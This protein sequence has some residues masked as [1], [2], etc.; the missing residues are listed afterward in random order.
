MALPACIDAGLAGIFGQAAAFLA[1]AFVVALVAAS[2]LGT[3]LVMW[4]YRR[5]VMTY[6][7]LPAPEPSGTTP[8][9]RPRP[10]PGGSVTASALVAAA[11]ARRAHLKRVLLAAC[12]L[13]ALAVAS[14]LTL[15]PESPVFAP[16]RLPTVPTGPRL[17][18]TALADLGLVGAL[19][20]PMVLIGL[21]HPRLG[22]LFWTRAVPLFWGALTLRIAAAS[23]DPVG[24]FIVL[25]MLLVFVAGPQVLVFYASIARRRARQLVPML[26][27]LLGL[28]FAGLL[29]AVA[30]M[31]LLARCGDDG[32]A[33]LLLLSLPLLLALCAWGAWRA[34]R[35]AAA[36]YAAKRLSDAQLQVAGWLVTLSAFL[37]MAIVGIARPEN[38]PWGLA[39]AAVTVAAFLAYLL[40]LR[41]VSAWPRPQSLLLLR[42]FAQDE[43]GEV[44]LD[45][46]AFRWRFVG[47]IHLIGGPDLARQTLDPQAL[48]LL[49]RGRTR[50]QFVAGHTQLAQRLAALDEAPD[51]DGR[52][53]IN[54]LYCFDRIWQA[55]V[56]ALLARSH[57]VLLDLRGYTAAR[58]GASFEIGLLARA[59]ALRSTV[60]LVDARTDLGAVRAMLD[61]AGL[62]R[63]DDAQVLAADRALDAQTLFA[64]LAV[65]AAQPPTG[66]S[67]GG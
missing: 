61:A 36:L 45:E 9:G 11:D 51:P 44:L 7:A 28:V 14:L 17:V 19:C 37:L 12:A 35:A 62:G 31:A 26:N 40:G 20:V 18:A 10:A 2:L 8:P 34:A 38:W 41:G 67:T 43:R 63:L 23:E 59:N 50:E 5:R 13:Y 6:M 27:L 56:A 60:C 1:G 32:A 64:A 58:T 25:P 49:V 46:T 47:P 29:L 54:V 33:G 39:L 3:P 57:A 65:A 55:A 48:M 30:V 42:V 16:A 66:S 52:Y 15:A 24:T 4:L 22:R 21:A 53:R